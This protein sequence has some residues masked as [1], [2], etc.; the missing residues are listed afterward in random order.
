MKKIL[1][2]DDSATMR[3]IITRVLRQAN[4]EVE[5]ILEAANGIEG[6]ER[7]VS[8]PDI[9]MILSDINMPEMNGIDF[10][11]ALRVNHDKESMPVVMITTE[12]GE[13]M[14]ETAIEAGANDYVTKPFTPDSIREA[15]EKY[16]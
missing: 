10:V 1:I 8:D 13:A 16:A 4:L 15:L 7:I 14:V 9:Q 5:T 12:G 11:K 6:L 2:V 3:K